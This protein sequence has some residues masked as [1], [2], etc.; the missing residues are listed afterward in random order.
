MTGSICFMALIGQPTIGEACVETV[1]DDASEV[2]A[3]LRRLTIFE[4][5]KSRIKKFKESRMRPRLPWLAS[6]PSLRI[7][8]TTMVTFHPRSCA[9]LHQ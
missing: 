9:F 3:R 4:H 2:L 5:R 1:L 8:F 7:R 6:N